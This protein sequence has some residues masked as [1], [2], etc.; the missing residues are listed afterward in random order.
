VAVFIL[1]ENLCAGLIPHI[2]T[3]ASRAVTEFAA[4]N[5]PRESAL[6]VAYLEGSNDATA[7]MGVDTHVRHKLPCGP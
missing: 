5:A 4:L 2:T 6:L 7:N 1:G 3:D